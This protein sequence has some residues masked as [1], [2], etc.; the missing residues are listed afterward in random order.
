M[1]EPNPAAKTAAAVFAIAITTCSAGLI[2]FGIAI[3]LSC[4]RWATGRDQCTKSWE[5]GLN[6]AGGGLLGLAG[7]WVRNPFIRK[8]KTEAEG[9]AAAV[10]PRTL[11]PRGPDGR[12][13]SV[14]QIDDPPTPL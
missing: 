10:P 14:S 8:G 4:E 13:R 9:G 6:A 5:T 11:P 12:F 3:G 7:T 1:A 2:L